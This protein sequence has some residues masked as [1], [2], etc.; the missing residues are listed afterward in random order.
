[1][2]SGG[3]WGG[4]DKRAV[5]GTPACGSGRFARICEQYTLVSLCAT[6]T[7]LYPETKSRIR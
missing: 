4:T 5:K 6:R 3:A 1:M 2:F 7:R